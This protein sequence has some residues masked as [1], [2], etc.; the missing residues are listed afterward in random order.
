MTTI[1]VTILDNFL[2]N[3]SSIRDWGL[4]LPFSLSPDGRW[5][6]KRTE[7][8]SKIHPYLFSYI[9]KKVL[10]LF[11]ETPPQ[12]KSILNFQL[13]EDYEGEGWIHQDQPNL[14]TYIIYLSKEDEINCG[15]S[16]YD[17]KPTFPHP[18]TSIEDMKT[19]SL[20]R[21]HHQTKVASPHIQKFQNNEKFK[22][23]KT[24][25][26]KDKYNRVLCFPSPQLHSA[27]NFSNKITSRLT[28]VGF[29]SDLGTNLTPILRSKTISP[30][31]T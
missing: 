3:P 2:D 26:I 10:S 31:Q 4:S 27:N 20:R 18:I 19:T 17:L 6:G 11:F 30:L 22:Y 14:I 12:Y 5:P 15:T 28:L 23:T 24:L 7:C 13:I 8:L 9:N 21:T 16:L 29:I 25:D 1:P